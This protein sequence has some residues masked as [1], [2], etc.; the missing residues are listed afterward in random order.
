[1][2]LGGNM[3]GHR[4]RFDQPERRGWRVGLRH[5]LVAG[6]LWA[7]AARAQAA[8]TSPA[9]RTFAPGWNIVSDPLVDPFALFFALQDGGLS[10]WAL[11]PTSPTGPKNVEERTAPQPSDQGYWVWSPHPVTVALQVP[12]KGTHR[13]HP[14]SAEDGWHFVSPSKTAAYGDPRMAQ[15]VGW[16]AQE[17]SFRRLRLG[18]S[19]LRGHGYWVKNQTP[20]ENAPQTCLPN[21]WSFEDA[22]T[23]IGA[24]PVPGDGSRIIARNTWSLAQSRPPYEPS[25]PGSPEAAP[26]EPPNRTRIILEPTASAFRAPFAALEG[27]QTETQKK[28][29]LDAHFVIAQSA[30]G[31]FE[32]YEGLPR[33]GGGPNALAH[34]DIRVA[35]MG[36]YEQSQGQNDE[37]PPH[38][39]DADAPES[40]RQPP[41]SAVLRLIEL[42]AYLSAFETPTDIVSQ[43][44]STHIQTEHL[45]QALQKRFFDPQPPQNQA[46]LPLS[47]PPKIGRRPQAP[48][49]FV[50]RP[51]EDVVYTDQDWFAVGGEVFGEDFVGLSINRMVVAEKRTSFLEVLFL[52]PGENHFTFVAWGRDGQSRKVERTIVRTAAPEGDARA[53][54]ASA[55][56]ATDDRR[57]PIVIRTH[58]TR[59]IVY[60]RAP[61]AHIEGTTSDDDFWGLSVNGLLI[62]TE[63]GS[64]SHPIQLSQ[65]PPSTTVTVSARDA[66]GNTTTDTVTWILDTEAPQIFLSHRAHIVT[67]EA[68]FVLRGSVFDPHLGDVFLRTAATATRTLALTDGRFESIV[69][70]EEGHNVFVVHASDLAGNQRSKEIIV[71][72]ARHPVART[73]PSPPTGLSAT[74]ADKRVRL[75]WSHPTRFEDGIPIPR[76]L[77]PTYTL[78]RDGLEVTK[79][80]SRHHED[81]PPGDQQ[82]VRYHVTAR[83]QDEGGLVLESVPSEPVTIDVTPPP[84]APS[85]GTFEA[86]S[87]LTDGSRTETLP[88][89]ALSVHRG[90]TYAHVAFVAS[91]EDH[92]EIRYAQSD[93]AGKPGT[94]RTALPIA[95]VPADLHITDLALS[96]RGSQVSIAWIQSPKNEHGG[97]GSGLY[98]S[99]SQNGGQSFD[100]AR[101]VGE[102]HVPNHWKRGLG[103][104]YDRQGHHH[105]VWG[106][107]NKIY[108]LKNL[109]G[110][111]SNVFDVRVREA[112]TERIK[113]QAQ[114]EP[115]KTGCECPNCWCDESYRLSEE[116]DPKNEN[117]PIG[118]YVYRIEDRYMA[119][120]ALH[121]DDEK[122]TIIGRQVRMWDNKAVPNPAW[123]TMVQTPVYD[124]IIVQRLRPT[125]LVVG[126]RSTW[127]QAQEPGDEGL[128]ETLG[129]AHQYLYSGTWH[130][131]ESILVAQ[132]PLEEG[133]WA[134]HPQAPYVTGRW[135]DDTFTDWRISSVT[136]GWAPQDTHP[137]L[138]PKVHSAQGNTMVAVFEQGPS[139]SPGRAGHNALYTTHSADGGLRWSPPQAVATGYLPQVAVAHPNETLLLFY[140]KKNPDAPGE[141]QAVRKTAGHAYSSPATLNHKPPR[142]IHWK[143]H[144]ETADKLP[145]APA[146]SAH[147]ELFF[148]AWVRKGEARRGD[149]IVTARASRDATFAHLDLALPEALTRGKGAAL[150][151]VSEN[152]FHMR[153]SSHGPVH[154]SQSAPHGVSSPTGA[155]SREGP[156]TEHPAVE[157]ALH[158][159][160]GRVVAALASVPVAPFFGEASLAESSFEATLSTSPD[161]PRF[162]ILATQ[163]EGNVHTH[164]DQ[165]LIHRNELLKQKTGRAGGVFF[166]QVEYQPD[167]DQDDPD[168]SRDAHYLAGFD[169]VWVYTQ[170]I[171]LAQLARRPTHGAEALGLARYLC[172]HAV[173][174]EGSHIILGWP[175]SWN[176]DRDGWQD[177]RLVTGATAWAIQGLG[178]FIASAAFHQAPAVDRSQIKDCYAHALVGLQDHRRRLPVSGGGTGSLM[179][180]G[181]TTAGLEN[182]GTP[183]LVASLS[184]PK[185][186]KNSNFEPWT[187]SHRFSYYSVLDAIGYPAFSQTPI[188]MCVNGPGTDCDAH[189]PNGPPWEDFLIEHEAQWAA[190]K[191]RTQASNVV[192]EHNLDVLSVLNHALSEEDALGPEDQGERTRWREHL[193]TW[194]NELRD[195][196]FDHLWD[197]EGWKQ[198]FAEALATL[199]AAPPSQALT[200]AQKESQTRR[201]HAMDEAL[202]KDTLGRMVTGGR[203]TRDEQGDFL[204]HASQHTAIDNCSWLSLSV[205]YGELEAVHTDRLARCLEYT[206]LQFAKELSFGED[207][208]D[209]YK[210]SCPPKKT[211]R[212]THYFQNAFRDPYIE[213][214]SL[215]TSSYHL[216]ATMGLILGLFRFAQ[217][218][219]E[220]PASGMF[221][222]EAHHL[223]AGAQG[224]VRDHGFVYSS[225][226]IQDLS[227]VLVSSTALVWFIDVYDELQK[228]NR[229]QDSL[230]KPY[231]RVGSAQL[232]STQRV[233]QALSRIQE[234]STDLVDSGLTKGDRRAYT[235]LMDQA[236]ALLVAT[237][238]GH[239]NRAIALAN[240]L[241][242]MREDTFWHAVLRDSLEPLDPEKLSLEESML[243]LYALA[244]FVHRYPATERALNVESVLI[245]DLEFFLKTYVV[246]QDG[247][248]AGLFRRPEDLK[249][250]NLEDN[251]MAYFALSLSRS[252][253]GGTPFGPTLLGAHPPLTEGLIRLCGLSSGALPARW[254]GEWGID[255]SALDGWRALMPCGLF[256][257]HLG[258]TESALSLIEAGQALESPKTWYPN[259]QNPPRGDEKT[260]AAT[261]RMWGLLAK[262]ALAAIDPRQDEIVRVDLASANPADGPLTE[263]LVTALVDLPQ[264]VLG[265]KRPPLTRA[266]AT[267]LKRTIPPEARGQLI[268]AL[269]DRFLE[270]VAALLSSTFRARHFD[271]LLTEMVTLKKSADQVR[272]ADAQ[273]SRDD[274]FRAMKTLLLRGLCA[275]D[276][277]IHQGS[278]SIEE[279]LGLGCK[280]TMVALRQLF[281]ARGALDRDTWILT[282]ESTNSQT[283]WDP[284]LALTPQKPNPTDGASVHRLG[285]VRGFWGQN[286]SSHIF[287][288]A[289]APLLL[290]ED[291]TTIEIQDAIRRRTQAAIQTGLEAAD[292]N[293]VI[294]YALG[295]IDP[296]EAFHPGST[297]YWKRSAIEFRMARSQA[298]APRVLFRLHG[299]PADAPPFPL[300]PPR[301][302]NVRALRAWFNTH[303]DGD[304]SIVAEEAGVAPKH[305]GSWLTDIHRMMRTGE[306]PR[307]SIDAL[308]HALNLEGQ[309]ALEDQL[310]MEASPFASLLGLSSNR[311]SLA[312]TTTG[313]LWGEL[314]PAF[315]SP[316]T[317]FGPIHDA[318]VDHGPLG[319]KR[320]FGT[321]VQMDATITPLRTQDGDYALLNGRNQCLFRIENH[322]EAQVTYE[323]LIDDVR[324][325]N[326][327]RFEDQNNAF[328]LRPG[329]RT[330]DVCASVPD[331]LGSEAEV[332]VRNITTREDFSFAFPVH[333]NTACQ[334]GETISSEQAA[335][336]I[337][338]REW[339]LDGRRSQDC[340]DLLTLQKTEPT[341]H[342]A[343]FSDE[344]FVV[345]TSL[346]LGT[347]RAARTAKQSLRTVSTIRGTPAAGLSVEGIAGVF[348]GIIASGSA[349][350]MS[351]DLAAEVQGLFLRSI[352]IFESPPEGPWVQV[353]WVSAWEVFAEGDQ[354]IRSLPIHNR[355]AQGGWSITGGFHDHALYGL[356]QPPVYSG[357]RLPLLHPAVPLFGHDITSKMAVYRYTGAVEL[358]VSKKDT[359]PQSDTTPLQDF[360]TEI[361]AYPEWINAFPPEFHYPII[362]TLFVDPPLQ[363]I[364]GAQSNKVLTRDRPGLF[365][366]EGDDVLF[367]HL[368]FQ[369]QPSMP[370]ELQNPT[371]VW[372][373][374][375]GTDWHLYGPKEDVAAFVGRFGYSAAAKKA[376]GE[377]KAPSPTKKAKVPPLTKASTIVRSDRIFAFRLSLRKFQARVK[378]HGPAYEFSPELATLTETVE[379]HLRTWNG[380][381]PVA[382][383]TSDAR[384]KVLL[385]DLKLMLSQ[386]LTKLQESTLHIDSEGSFTEVEQSIER[387]LGLTADDALYRHSQP[388]ARWRQN[389]VSAALKAETA[390]VFQE[391]ENKYV[392]LKHDAT[393]KPTVNEALHTI[394]YLNGN[395]AFTQVD[396]F[397]KT[398]AARNWV[399]SQQRT[400]FFVIGGAWRREYTPDGDFVDV[401]FF[402]EEELIL[403]GQKGKLYE[404]N[405]RE[406]ISKL[407]H[408]RVETRSES[409][410]A[411]DPIV[412]AGTK[413]QKA[414]ETW[415]WLMRQPSTDAFRKAKNYYSV[416]I[417]NRSIY[418][419]FP[420]SFHMPAFKMNRYLL[421][422]VATDVQDY[423]QAR[424]TAEGYVPKGQR[425]PWFVTDRLKTNYYIDGEK[426]LE[427]AIEGYLKKEPTLPPKN[428]EKATATH[429]EVKLRN[430]LQIAKELISANHG[431]YAR[432]PEAAQL[433]LE[434]EALLPWLQKKTEVR[435]PLRDLSDFNA[436]ALR[437]IEEISAV[438]KA[439]G[440]TFDTSSFLTSVV[441]IVRN[442]IARFLGLTVD[443]RLYKGTD[444]GEIGNAWATAAKRNV[445]LVHARRVEGENLEI[446]ATNRRKPQELGDWTVHSAQYLGTPKEDFSDVDAW[447]KKVADD[448]VTNDHDFFT[449]G[450]SWARKYAADGAYIGSSSP[451]RAYLLS[452][453]DLAQATRIE[454]TASF[455][456][457]DEAK[458]QNI[459]TKKI[460]AKE[461]NSGDPSTDELQL[462]IAIPHQGKDK[463][464]M[465]FGLS[466]A[467]KLTSSMK[468]YRFVGSGYSLKGVE[469]ELYPFIE[470]QVGPYVPEDQ[471]EEWF[472]TLWNRSKEIFGG[473]PEARKKMREQDA[474]KL[475][476]QQ[477]I[478]LDPLLV[479][480]YDRF[481]GWGEITRASKNP[482][483][484]QDLVL[485]TRNEEPLMHQIFVPDGAYYLAIAPQ[486]TGKQGQ[487]VFSRFGDYQYVGLATHNFAGVGV[488]QTG[489][490]PAVKK[491]LPRG[492][493]GKWFISAPDVD[494]P[495]WFDKKGT[496]LADPKGVFRFLAQSHSP[497]PI[498]EV[499]KIWK[500]HPIEAMAYAY[501]GEHGYVAFSH[502]DDRLWAELKNDSRVLVLWTQDGGGWYPK[503]SLKKDVK[504]Q[505][506][507][508]VAHESRETE[509]YI[510]RVTTTEG[511]VVGHPKLG[512]NKDLILRS[513]LSLTIEKGMPTA[514][515]FKTDK[516]SFSVVWDI[517]LGADD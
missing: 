355:D 33:Y 268:T 436:G 222:R 269:A 58:P 427:S 387:F 300:S 463:L 444:P 499:A 270:T 263:A 201:M 301:A 245:E 167:K 27:S 378:A 9:K 203:L 487:T 359:P 144:V 360:L 349:E 241:L 460:S 87:P 168:T 368:R 188:R 120:P 190:L 90:K 386:T 69:S 350:G 205:Q 39:F 240:G 315:G 407:L 397:A 129:Y 209:P 309:N 498:N 370:I 477:R 253:L 450:D 280:T 381:E 517:G 135:S 64:F 227:A 313:G 249:V 242:S 293:T 85:P 516:G 74:G 36:P 443:N 204:L 429:A 479:E 392:L 345:K 425:L 413:P 206:I 418:I 156:A 295:D 194:R 130:E 179:T 496:R 284:S 379:G 395:A 187:S 512:Q 3:I 160:V 352:R 296:I 24:C 141:I 100:E 438:L 303:A 272:Q 340:P 398:E 97:G 484:P 481:P 142:P 82:R 274:R 71:T 173:R 323:V 328:G 390:L 489:L 366:M 99:I 486:K 72:Y 5:A 346:V 40:L 177:A 431:I 500:K 419:V 152:K 19:L 31:H 18:E 344:S 112:A 250:A 224:F 221:L 285:D 307:A 148:A 365:H 175:F 321:S 2:A 492:Q 367:D 80:A 302:D 442:H 291:A 468:P 304:L 354:T 86:P 54:A 61:H 66:S 375:P 393:K 92:E 185:G 476:D 278:L 513:D 246:S 338:G 432:W 49:L 243:A 462:V 157:I 446:Y 373:Q 277:L 332:V 353:G 298:I 193:T 13:G 178:V 509:T 113:Y 331:G 172:H 4:A 104:G 184:K 6:L 198:E 101:A 472:I 131:R 264:G 317:S 488:S 372:D 225:Q 41:L 287:L 199:D 42:V 261:H 232:L 15:V 503:S 464:F 320:L 470:K 78:Y 290:S 260:A 91:D 267:T 324:F 314:A 25:H 254:A 235:L 213:P 110:P 107:R 89:T 124:P 453:L 1:M 333:H 348:G 435:A 134:D 507:V 294:T 384:F 466:A 17:Q 308:V 14:T 297:A 491:A 282:L 426:I 502:K 147:Q 98:V 12:V 449:F 226:R 230:L 289:E 123:E 266:Q 211:Y 454:R 118:P 458:I 67:H 45:V 62:G 478:E 330:R 102:S 358:N 401:V 228:A 501:S 239:E 35:I 10:L 238:Q 391:K 251:L 275:S 22:K 265:A 421:E 408:L 46:P 493:K 93:R 424:K 455:L 105:L 166:Y 399:H 403:M 339:A 171:T 191:T 318:S 52:A 256:A 83:F 380:L 139:S 26:T 162:E 422:G 440:A 327:V 196:I 231:D 75:W 441:P 145:G 28:A 311:A 189:P 310:R 56:D 511:E 430:S 244:W 465:R 79:T 182:V 51:S 122:V 34:T 273:A 32:I 281:A 125:R 23:V 88:Q 237:N 247:P 356:V 111:P 508:L 210:A 417:L 7:S 447:A 480:V 84:P 223:W 361:D 127:K 456:G 126:F 96:A 514:A 495:Y 16:N 116:P 158:Q 236:L 433:I 471:E 192:T 341:S 217:A 215:Q 95:S 59:D 410:Y 262:R 170:G 174:K 151:V 490:W 47:P 163:K 138:Y 94:F 473:D 305:Q 106:E 389:R 474:P 44:R 154:I 414:T 510:F 233:G 108:Y 428:K 136:H 149:H 402:V 143:S 505:D 515:Q 202:A 400:N 343:H 377:K 133:A 448:W 121:I 77:H 335:E 38:G 208:C 406:L 103:V 283:P 412:Y 388:I 329:P 29:G 288:K 271:T 146:L 229:G 364:G 153:L 334:S 497:I 405:L 159:G 183:H 396:V 181:W 506:Y 404:E 385:T 60:T 164:Y 383:M 286:P 494:P 461:T 212:G 337:A 30:E 70:L 43:T 219:P 197:E 394:T 437:T 155:S 411:V 409:A 258:A 357:P 416:S 459:K 20:P 363:S 119:Q 37:G 150:T 376:T 306:V 165:A 214:S 132:R 322:S 325:G 299:R 169:R 68:Q 485:L 220:H 259:T 255:K 186:S 415:E 218:H 276:A 374:W 200:R 369:K 457:V 248:L 342:N 109:D 351:E 53:Q 371:Y 451:V 439:M 65:A 292:A 257:A 347:L 55:V 326:D 73:R 117:R 8:T 362:I 63:S 382:D 234:A 50:F 128:L 115:G 48:A 252:L 81:H 445:V 76:G 312:A 467:E 137:L 216:E 423:A 452:N 482:I 469:A 176:T 57:P 161:A 483:E 336:R 475:T 420:I 434:L 195:G 114:Y 504:N 279:R 316:E 207:L 21:T 140:A 11:N 180:A 319:E